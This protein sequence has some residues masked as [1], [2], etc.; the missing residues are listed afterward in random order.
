MNDLCWYLGVV[1]RTQRELWQ[2]PLLDIIHPI[3]KFGTYWYNV[4]NISK[5]LVPLSKGSSRN[6]N[7]WNRETSFNNCIRFVPQVSLQFLLVLWDLSC[8]IPAVQEVQ[9]LCFP[10]LLQAFHQSKSSKLA[11]CK[12]KWLNVRMDYFLSYCWQYLFRRFASISNN[13]HTVRTANSASNILHHHTVQLMHLLFNNT[14][15]VIKYNLQT[16]W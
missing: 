2:Y 6:Q 3:T 16:K 8:S 1:S 10:H 4:I 9:Y 7:Q 13:K 5:F 14:R 11:R 15:S 12:V